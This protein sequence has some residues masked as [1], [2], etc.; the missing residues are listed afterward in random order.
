[1]RTAVIFLLMLN[2]LNFF[3]RA[4]ELY[5]SCG[6]AMEICPNQTYSVNNINANSTSCV[7]CEDD[8]NFCFTS[9][10]SIWFTFTTN[11]VG[12]NIQI[13]FSNLTFETNPGQDSELQAALIEA[14]SAC[15]A[16]TYTQLGS[17][18]FNETGNF[19]LNSGLLNPN[20]TYY[21]V[22]D[23]DNNGAGISMAA[24]CTFDLIISGP[25]ADR[26]LPT[27]SILTA[28]NTVCL[29]ENVV[30][31]CDL[32]DCSD[33]SEFRWYINGAMAAT[34]TD[35][36]FQTSNLQDGDIVSVETNCYSNCP[37]TVQDVSM[38]MSVFTVNVNAGV[39]VW[40]NA[41]TTFNLN[42][43]TTAPVYYWSPSFA[44]SNPN[45]LNPT[46]TPMETTTYALTAE[47]NGC[48][49]TDYIIATINEELEIPNTFSPNGDNTNDT[50]VIEGLEA[51]P[52]NLM[53]IYTRWGQKVFETSSYSEIK[54]WDG[55]EH[56]E[57]VYYYVL[58]LNNGSGEK[59][60]GTIT[61]IR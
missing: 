25:G 9:Q 11:A 36:V 4:Q 7:N 27:A 5:N 54:A 30:F 37:V 6:S 29:N 1:M 61:L 43:S 26:P 50:W 34:T 19:T 17:C 28:S 33:T 21:I 55:G 15:D 52:D 59:R 42:G 58:D 56:Q 38:P 16:S 22:V 3:G 44:V 51:Y 18:H 24:E 53:S 60:S 35:A 23:G 2:F 10:N 40:V 20:T 47:E 32:T 8:F 46:V 49:R 57:G 31:T 48:V 12:G 39:D 13:D 45:I 14:G 41:G